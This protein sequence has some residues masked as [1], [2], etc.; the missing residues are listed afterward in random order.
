L[1]F[2]LIL[3][4]QRLKLS[5]MCFS[6]SHRPTQTYT[7]KNNVSHIAAEDTV[8]LGINEFVC[9]GYLGSSCHGE[10]NA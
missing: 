5:A 9:L 8:L 3:H 7:D 2:W 1:A 10:I 4:T 6:I